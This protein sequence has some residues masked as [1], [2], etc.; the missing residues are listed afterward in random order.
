MVPLA[1]TTKHFRK[2]LHQFPIISSK[3]K[4][5][6]KDKRK[7]TEE[8]YL[9]NSDC[10]YDPTLIP[11][12]DKAILGKDS[13]R[14]ISLM[15]GEANILHKLSKSYPIMYTNYCVYYNIVG[16][17]SCAFLFQHSKIN[18]THYIIRL[19]KKDH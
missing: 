3:K 11:K 8:C 13:Y 19:K 12:L 17:I 9:T 14:P 1:N 16:F 7:P 5:E 4:K 2:N 15:D 18:R 10:Q 6:R